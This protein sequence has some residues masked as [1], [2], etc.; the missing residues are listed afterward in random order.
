MLAYYRGVCYVQ[1]DIEGDNI[2]QATEWM[3]EAVNNPGPFT[4]QAQQALAGIQAAQ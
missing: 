1:L 3:N 4:E 2:R